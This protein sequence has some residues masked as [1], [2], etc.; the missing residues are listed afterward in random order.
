MRFHETRLS[1]A[2]VVEIEPQ[3]DERGMFARSFCAREFAEHGLNDRFVQCNVSLNARCGTLR[4]MHYQKSPFEESKLV[5]CTR[6]RVYDVIVDMRRQSAT[7]LDWFAV[8][9]NCEEH[10]ALYI[11]AGFAHGFQTLVDE[12]EVFY[13]MSEYYRADSGA[14]VRWD[15]P[16]FGIE[17]P[18]SEPIL[19]TRDASYANVQP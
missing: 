8:E 1:G 10:R 4:G 11:P 19:S 17:W 7:Y 3:R 13:Q 9:L 5:R 6:G 14:G 16:A 15:D 18:L 2:F 12:A